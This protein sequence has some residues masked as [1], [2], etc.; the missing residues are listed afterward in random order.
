MS[1][2][3]RSALYVP[4]SSLKSSLNMEYALP[5]KDTQLIQF[6]VIQ[7]EDIYTTRKSIYEDSTFQL[8]RLLEE[9]YAS[10]ILS[11]CYS[12]CLISYQGYLRSQSV[13]ISLNQVCVVISRRST[14]AEVSLD[15]YIPDITGLSFTK[16]E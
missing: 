14:E 13:H 9:S 6:L 7:R 16:V 15:M 8:I 2:S 1:R 12:L 10:R 3:I 4:G 11:F 5:K